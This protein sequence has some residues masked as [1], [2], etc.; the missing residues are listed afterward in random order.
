[1]ENHLERE[2][3]GEPA[4]HIFRD[5]VLSLRMNAETDASVQICLEVTR[6]AVQNSRVGDVKVQAGKPGIVAV[7]HWESCSRAV[8]FN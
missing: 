6:K 8:S 3:Y 4:D 7:C 5:V 1:M 2:I